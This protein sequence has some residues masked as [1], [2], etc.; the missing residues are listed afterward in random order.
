M[1]VNATFGASVRRAV[2]GD[3]PALL[4]VSLAAIAVSA[5][6]HYDPAQ[7]EA[8]SRRR[9]LV[10]HERL[11]ASTA[12]L[13]A[14]VGGAVAGFASLALTPVLGLER[15]EVDQ[16][17][18]HPDHGGRGVARRLLAAVDEV[19][20]DG[21]VDVLHAHASWR[22][23]PVFERAGYAR[24]RTETVVLDGQVLTRELVRRELPRPAPG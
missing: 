15:G 3:A 10:Q 14:E 6:G 21:G 9:T 1:D 2:A 8:W 24:V 22:A 5:A 23:V 13:V 19:A 17:F 4:A 7:R 12:T 16:L 11:V 18:V 20:R